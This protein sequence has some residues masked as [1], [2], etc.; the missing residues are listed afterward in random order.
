[1]RPRRLE[2]LGGQ[3]AVCSSG[4]PRPGCRVTSPCLPLD[5]WRAGSRAKLTG[6]SPWPSARAEF[7]KQ[8]TETQLEAFK[9]LLKAYQAEIDALTRRSK[10]S[11][12]AFL[13]AYKLL[14]EAPD[15]YPLLDAAVVRPRLVP[16]CGQ[17]LR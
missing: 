7:K 11:E 13:G 1:M 17:V 3:R 10:A 2:R 15:P 14:A 16:V 9:P 8:P 4:C 5:A 6:S 12:S